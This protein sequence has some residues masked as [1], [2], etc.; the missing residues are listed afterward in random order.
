MLAAK[1]VNQDL[2]FWGVMDRAGMGGGTGM[3]VQG[4]YVQ[5]DVC[6]WG[7]M[8]M[9]IFDGSTSTSNVSI[10]VLVSS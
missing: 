3:Y 7:C 8:Y 9:G 4:M 2:N 6:T 10:Q 1:V 5:G